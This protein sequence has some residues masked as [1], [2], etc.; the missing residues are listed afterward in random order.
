MTKRI[1]HVVPGLADETN[2]IAV[3]AR[4]IAAS[5]SAKLVEAADATAL[6][7]HLR[8]GSFDEVWVHSMW[9]PSVLM[10]C[11]RVLGAKVLLVRMPHGCLDPVRLGYHGWKKMLV[12]PIER[13]FLRR[14]KKV[15]ATCAA[16][17]EWIRAYEPEAHIELIDVK[18]YFNLSGEAFAKLRRRGILPRQNKDV[19]LHVLYLGRRH[20]L[21]GV[22]YLE[23]AVEGLCGI[24]LRIESDLHGEAKEAAWAWCDVFVLPTL[25]EN[26]GLVVAEA[27]EHGKCVVTTDGAPVWLDQDGVVCLKGFRAASPVERVRMLK[28]ALEALI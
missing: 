9:S 14:A 18:R 8:A 23:Q 26:F 10:A 22:E 21:K 27:L 11:R 6:K 13:F 16:E 3:A 25:S 19:P 15:V 4:L 12:K 20:P 5:Q 2:G 1:L 17:A 24:E 28:H 7:C